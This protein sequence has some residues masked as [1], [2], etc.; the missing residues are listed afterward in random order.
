MRCV[1]YTF[2]D[3]PAYLAAHFRVDHPELL[4]DV[5]DGMPRVNRSVAMAKA[6]LHHMHPDVSAG[7]GAAAVTQ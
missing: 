3:R 2:D 1:H 4:A 7:A 5:E 6:H